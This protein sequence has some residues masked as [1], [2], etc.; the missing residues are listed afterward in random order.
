MLWLP[1]CGRDCNE[2]L[3]YGWGYLGNLLFRELEHTSVKVK[4][5]IERRSVGDICDIPIYSLQDDLPKAD[6]VIV[7]VLYDTEKIRS[8]IGEK[9]GQDCMVIC[10]EELIQ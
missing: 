9:I 6:A 7:T 2:I 8:D 4:G 1:V 5:I 10:L 3:I